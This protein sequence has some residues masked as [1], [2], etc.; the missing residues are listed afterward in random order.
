MFDKTGKLFNSCSPGKVFQAFIEATLKI[1][2]KIYQMNWTFCNFI[3]TQRQ[4]IQQNKLGR[5][6][7]KL[8]SISY[9]EKVT[10]INS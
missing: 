5:F 6:N 7:I 4:Q 1:L 9:H 3:A 2:I 10:F 8:L